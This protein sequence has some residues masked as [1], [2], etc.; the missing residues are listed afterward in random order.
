V[1]VY[2]H[3]HWVRSMWMRGRPR[4]VVRLTNQ[5]LRRGLLCSDAGLHVIRHWI[6][7]RSFTSPTG[8]TEATFSFA[9]RLAFV[10]T[11]SGRSGFPSAARRPYPLAGMPRLAHSARAPI[12]WFSTPGWPASPDGS[13]SPGME[14]CAVSVDCVL[15]AAEAQRVPD[16]RLVT[17]DDWSPELGLQRR[18]DLC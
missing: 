5:P 8:A 12:R 18:D 7:A 1:G 16:H 2:S 6:T 14:Q 4:G 3:H 10:F 15:K 17:C 13:A 9:A 11:A